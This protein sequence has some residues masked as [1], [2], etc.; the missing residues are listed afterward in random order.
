MHDQNIANKVC[1]RYH[2]VWSNIWSVL[3]IYPTRAPSACDISPPDTICGEERIT[4]YGAFER[5]VHRALND[6][7]ALESHVLLHLSGREFT[8]RAGGLIILAASRREGVIF[9]FVC[10]VLARLKLAHTKT[11]PPC[12]LLFL[13]ILDGR[14][15]AR[16]KDTS[17]ASRVGEWSI[18]DGNM[19]DSLLEAPRRDL[20]TSTW[21]LF[22][23]DRRALIFMC[24][25]TMAYIS[26]A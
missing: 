15:M 4:N 25:T 7:F 21:Y 26:T 10:F 16:T 22:I 9:L 8:P 18:L 23:E 13:T 17:E 6:V 11:P 5:S 24:L 14:R 12:R 1:A 3:V 2:V 20:S 19:F